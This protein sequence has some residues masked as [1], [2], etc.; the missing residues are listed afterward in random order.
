MGIIEHPPCVVYS[1]TRILIIH[2][3]EGTHESKIIHPLYYEG[4]LF[5]KITLLTT[6][7]NLE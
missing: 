4:A 3:P 1:D 2:H 5:C 7:I 6:Y